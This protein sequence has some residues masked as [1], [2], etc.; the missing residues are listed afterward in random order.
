M[1]NGDM[2]DA[3]V[4]YQGSSEDMTA[5]GSIITN[6]APG[7]GTIIYLTIPVYE[8]GAAAENELRLSDAADL[9]SQAKSLSSSKI[10]DDG[11]T[12]KQPP[13]FRALEP[14]FHSLYLSSTHPAD[15]S[16][17]WHPSPTRPHSPF[18]FEF[19]GRY[20][21]NRPAYAVFYAVLHQRYCLVPL[22]SSLLWSHKRHRTAILPP[23]HAR[24]IR[25]LFRPTQLPTSPPHGATSHLSLGLLPKADHGWRETH[26][27]HFWV[28]SGL[29]RHSPQPVGPFNLL[30]GLSSHLRHQPFP[31]PPRLSPLYPI[32]LSSNRRRHTRIL[33]PN[34]ALSSDFFY[35]TN[36]FT[37]PSTD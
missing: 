14:S 11:S 17:P 33:G 6:R 36:L 13:V 26:G 4:E 32:Y 2:L 18:F 24:S 15:P 30:A 19:L 29:L 1:L 10:A 22:T 27:L 21:T 37:T 25:G 5:A 7:K 28:H 9:S 35:P 8:D 12:R 34:D 20:S 3:M 23:S 16:S 31:R